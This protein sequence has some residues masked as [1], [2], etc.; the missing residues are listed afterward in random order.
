MSTKIRVPQLRRSFVPR[1]RLVERLARGAAG[2]L[3]LQERT[4]GWIAALHLAAISLRSRPG[5]APAL[6]EFPWGHEHLVEYLAAE[7]LSALPGDLR[8]FVVRTSVLERLSASS[9]TR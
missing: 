5:P 4:E 2:R 3:T 7:V 8:E 6:S 9:A 1:E